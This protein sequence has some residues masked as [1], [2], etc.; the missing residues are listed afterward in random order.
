MHSWCSISC[1]ATLD[2]WCRFACS[3]CKGWL[4]FS[5]VS[6]VSWQPFWVICLLYQILLLAFLHFALTVQTVQPHW[7]F[8]TLKS[9][10]WPWSF[11]SV[12][13]RIWNLPYGSSH[14]RVFRLLNA[15]QSHQVFSYIRSWSHSITCR[16]QIGRG[17]QPPQHFRL[18]GPS[19]CCWSVAVLLS[20]CCFQL[21]S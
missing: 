17:N 7:A 2:R 14:W 12:G 9:T 11:Q 21:W 6:V 16:L 4:C 20:L 18:P 13:R 1:A 8:D 5:R 3:T 15:H 19:W 10:S